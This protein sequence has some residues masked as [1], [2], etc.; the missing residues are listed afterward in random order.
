MIRVRPRKRYYFGRIEFQQPKIDNWIRR[1]RSFASRDWFRSEIRYGLWKRERN[2][3]YHYRIYPTVFEGAKRI[4]V[5]IKIIHNPN[6]SQEYSYDHVYVYHA[7]VL[8]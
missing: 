4:R 5:V 1:H 7:H 6:G 2:R 8:P 3:P